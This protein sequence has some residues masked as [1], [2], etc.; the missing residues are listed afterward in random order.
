MTPIEA[1]KKNN[2]KVVYNNRKH[3]REIQ[4]PKIN[5]GDLVPTANIKRVFST[6]DST[7]WSYILYRITEVIHDTI[8]SYRKKYL[9]ERY[10]ENLIGP[11]NF[12][13][14]EN[15]QI[16]KELNLTQ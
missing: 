13:L 15:N 3:K 4:T 12:N 2:E 5:T 6:G 10:N 9:P 1:S 11:T 16:R 7:K 8:P 14:D